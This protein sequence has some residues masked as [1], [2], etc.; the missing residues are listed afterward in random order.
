MPVL[1]CIGLIFYLFGFEEFTLT[2]VVVLIIAVVLWVL[3][4]VWYIYYLF[5]VKKH[6]DG[7]SNENVP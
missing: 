6:K 5:F 4:L 3:N 2:R 1:I 7:Y